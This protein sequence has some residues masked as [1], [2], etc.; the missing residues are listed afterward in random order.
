VLNVSDIE[1]ASYVNYT[2][3]KNKFTKLNTYDVVPQANPEFDVFMGTFYTYFEIY[4]L[5]PG[6]K[7]TIQSSMRD[8]NEKVVLKNELIESVSPGMY[9]V[10]V[11]Y[12]DIREIPSGIYNYH[13]L[14][15]DETSGEIAEAS[16]Q[17][18]M[19]QKT[20]M[21]NLVYDE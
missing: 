20:E 6:G 21:D 12:M 19:I 8:L 17:V 3:N 7:Y 14:I 2:Q 11:D 18:Y 9:D 4:K 1:I 15:K 16:K 10:V 13:V 5:T